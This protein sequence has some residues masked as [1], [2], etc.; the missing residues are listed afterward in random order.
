[1]DDGA[2]IAALH[3]S[4]QPSAMTGYPAAEVQPPA[5]GA[6]ALD[7]APTMYE[8]PLPPLAEQRRRDA[9]A[10]AAAAVH[11]GANT[12]VIAPETQARDLADTQ[13]AVTAAADADDVLQRREGPLE[14]P[15]CHPL[16]VPATPEA[17][18]STLAAQSHGEPL[19]ADGGDG[20]ADPLQRRIVRRP[21]TCSSEPDSGRSQDAVVSACHGCCPL[22]VQRS[23][24]VRDGATV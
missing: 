7:T 2:S 23:P 3:Q 1:M 5:E 10:A 16:S 21:S 17:W 4:R 15:P 9:A 19:S 11:E 6:Q 8:K 13:A 22:L 14:A 12:V 20:T 18:P 24:H